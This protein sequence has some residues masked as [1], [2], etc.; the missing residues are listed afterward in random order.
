MA[1]QGISLFPGVSE[2]HQHASVSSVR[3]QFAADHRRH[4][5]RYQ[6][7]LI[8]LD[9]DAVDRLIGEMRSDDPELANAFAQMADQFEYGPILQLIVKKVSV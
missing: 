1:E 6:R 7:A 2:C 8:E 9:V 4:Q 5:S 3:Q